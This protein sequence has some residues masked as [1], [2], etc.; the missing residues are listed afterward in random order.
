[1]SL[2]LF[3]YCI[4]LSKFL[5][6][7]AVQIACSEGWFGSS[8]QY[9]CHC[10]NNNC[11]GQGLCLAGSSCERGWFGPLCQYQDLATV[12]AILTPS[13]SRINDGND[14]TCSSLQSIMITWDIAHQITWARVEVMGQESLSNITFSIRE[15]C[16]DNCS[17][18]IREITLLPV[19]DRITDIVL[20]RGVLAMEVTFDFGASI[21][22]CSININGGRNVALK[23]ATWQSSVYREPNFE[24]GSHLAVDGH[25]SNNFYTYLSCSHT[26]GDIIGSWKVTLAKSENVH[27]YVL[28]NRDIS[29]QRLQGFNLVAYTS[30]NTVVLNYTDQDEEPQSVYTITTRSMASG[31][32]GLECA[33][34]CN[35]NDP[36]E[37]CFVATGGCQSG[38][39]VGY[40]G[41]GCTQASVT[42]YYVANSTSAGC[43]DHIDE[44]CPNCHSDSDN[45]GLD[46]RK[47]LIKIF[48]QAQRVQSDI[49]MREKCTSTF[50]LLNTFGLALEYK[51]ANIHCF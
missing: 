1:M 49:G 16:S 34:T 27:R 36:T 38:C 24:F 15:K 50:S 6:I 30:N 39:A 45:S 31:K 37:T 14:E 2:M 23:Q 25:N 46:Q 35:C 29:Q 19:D 17:I 48:K 4:F 51:C 40:Q 13:D 47:L 28:Y 44:Q 9:K 22:L 41:E 42:N 32:Y 8:C 43:V 26:L 7:E 18:I 5:R 11:D 33:K 20:T 10:V 12:G 21:S 3:Y